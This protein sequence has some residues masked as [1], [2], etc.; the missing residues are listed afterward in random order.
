MSGMLE[1]D[2]HV[3][4]SSENLA[5]QQ[6]Y[7]SSD[8]LVKCASVNDDSLGR[9]RINETTF[10]SS[11]SD[12]EGQEKMYLVRTE[13]DESG[14]EG[15]SLDTVGLAD[16][17]SL[18]IATS[19]HSEHSVSDMI[20]SSPNPQPCISALSG[21]PLIGNHTQVLTLDQL[22]PERLIELQN[23]GLIQIA[24]VA[25]SP[26]L[27]SG[28]SN[29]LGG[30]SPNQPLSIA[31]YPMKQNEEEVY[32][33]HDLCVVCGDRASGRHYGAK[34]CEGCKGF[35]KRSI[36]KKL[37][38]TCRGNRDCS[39]NKTHRNRCQY[40]RFQK[41]IIMGMKSDSVQCERSPMHKHDDAHHR[42][43]GNSSEHFIKAFNKGILNRGI[44]GESSI[45]GKESPEKH[46]QGNLSTL[47][48]VVSSIANFTKQEREFHSPE[49]NGR[50]E[51]P[52]DLAK[53]LASLNSTLKRCSPSEDYL[54]QTQTPILD[55]EGPLM[56]ESNFLFELSMPTP[57]PDVFNVHYVCESASRLLFLSAQ[58]ARSIFAFQ[59]LRAECHTSLL[60]DC[61]HE[62]F[63]LGLAQC[64]R[65]MNLDRIISTIIR[66]LKTTLQQGKLSSTH[67]CNV[68]EH[69][70]KLQ[71]FVARLQKLEV[72]PHEFAYIKALALFSPDH[73]N[74]VHRTQIQ[75]FQSRAITELREH[76]VRNYP[77]DPDRTSL[78]LLSLP[79]L[80]SLNSS[81]T[82][83][84]FFAG[85]IGN[86]QID[87][88]IP[89]ILKME[90]GEFSTVSEA[91][92]VP[93]LGQ[94]AHDSV[95]VAE[96]HNSELLSQNDYAIEG[97]AQENLLH[98]TSTIQTSL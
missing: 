44:D 69:L 85:L 39:V 19:H 15:Q 60:R 48:N 51:K 93:D 72:D 35:F 5:R 37:T 45:S 89:Y 22:T 36:R 91:S 70:N 59:L 94:Y 12:I 75:R 3:V 76:E 67:V 13:S 14:N 61:W 97:H 86:V 27:V 23:K 80:R 74:Q 78:L 71:D 49:K 40:C 54:L 32:L 6:E 16:N 18:S 47:A 58:W 10:R 56:T 20:V 68:S 28:R 46:N 9:K 26:F 62:L 90:T 17:P 65:S 43:L 29:S 79:S 4:A 82:E 52:V 87:S 34:S 92:P 55:F 2:L 1:S 31:T 25:S 53:A 96:Y 42:L 81:I 95:L 11:N 57:S 64:S 41:C 7:S 30:S 21:N 24:S 50:T 63:V 84:I 66:H 77:E 8:M 98:T 83:E 88:I 33:G 73:V 38:Y